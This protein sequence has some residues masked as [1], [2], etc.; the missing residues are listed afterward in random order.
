MA[1]VLFTLP[2]LA[3]TYGA[4]VD[5]WRSWIQSGELKAVNMSK[6]M[7]SKKPRF[8]VKQSELDKFFTLR[9]TG[10]EARTQRRKKYRSTPVER[11]V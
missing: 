7:A 2:E 1:D 10:T 6:S 4:S 9:Q 11:H 8:M 3:D 5:T